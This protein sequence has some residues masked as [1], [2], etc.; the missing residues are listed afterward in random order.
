MGPEC[1]KVVHALRVTRDFILFRSRRKISTVGQSPRDCTLCQRTFRVETLS[2]YWQRSQVKLT[3][4]EDA[5]TGN[6]LEK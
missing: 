1:W 4:L 5:P 3:L 6:M 2:L